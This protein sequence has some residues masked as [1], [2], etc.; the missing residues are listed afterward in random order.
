[1]AY[2]YDPILI[3]NFVITF[4]LLW[5]VLHHYEVVQYNPVDHAT[6]VFQRHVYYNQLD[7]SVTPS[8]DALLSVVSL[9]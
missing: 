1:M 7:G 8:A 3:S 6:E 5:M 9:I 2:K 4:G